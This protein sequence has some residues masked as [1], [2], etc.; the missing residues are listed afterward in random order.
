MTDNVNVVTGKIL[1]NAIDQAFNYTPP[2]RVHTVST[3]PPTY[4]PSLSPSLDRLPA[5]VVHVNSLDEL[6][7]TSLAQ[8]LHGHLAAGTIDSDAVMDRCFTQLAEKEVD[9]NFDSRRV[10]TE[11]DVTR[12]AYVITEQLRKF[13]KAIY[14]QDVEIEEHLRLTEQIPDRMLLYSALACIVWEDKSWRA[15]EY[16]APQIVDLAKSAA[17]KQLLLN[18]KEAHGR[19]ILYKV[20]M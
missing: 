5:F 15:F 6:L 7:I 14:K 16:C 17:G 20:C 13:V 12:V 9:S 3:S 8:T 11:G 19:A 10:K 2:Q 18:R 4:Q 1:L